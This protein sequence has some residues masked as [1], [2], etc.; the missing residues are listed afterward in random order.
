MVVHLIFFPSTDSRIC[1]AALGCPLSEPVWFSD[2]LSG[3]GVVE[4][5]SGR[6]HHRMH[7]GRLIRNIGKLLIESSKLDILSEQMAV[8]QNLRIGDGKCPS[9]LVSIIQFE[10]CA[11]LTHSQMEHTILICR[12]RI[13]LFWGGMSEK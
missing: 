3:A 2:A 6:E 1:H 7:L 5:R 12:N 13:E 10:G 4:A 8:D 9:L 11:I